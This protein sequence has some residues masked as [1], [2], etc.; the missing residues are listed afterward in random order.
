MLRSSWRLYTDGSTI[1]EGTVGDFLK[2]KETTRSTGAIV[3]GDTYTATGVNFVSTKLKQF[4]TELATS[5]LA[6]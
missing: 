2:G 3:G 6:R 1:K 4:L 5:M